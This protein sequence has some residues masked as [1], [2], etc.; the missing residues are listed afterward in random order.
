MSTSTGES[1]WCRYCG[2]PLDGHTAAKHSKCRKCRKRILIC[3]VIVHSSGAGR[4]ICHVPCQC[5]PEYY[6]TEEA[7]PLAQ[8][9]YAITHPDYVAPDD[10]DDYTDNTQL[11]TTASGAT[12]EA[13]PTYVD[14]FWQGDDFGFYDINQHLIL[15]RKSDWQPATTLYEGEPTPCVQLY[16]GTTNLWYFT[17]TLDIGD[18]QAVAKTRKGKASSARRTQTTNA[19]S[20]EAGQSDPHRRT[21]SKESIDPLQWDQARFE[22]ETMTAGIANLRVGESSQAPATSDQRVETVTVSARYSGKGKVTFKPKDGDLSGQRMV[23]QKKEWVKDGSGYK[24]TSETYNC[25]FVA[26]EIKPAK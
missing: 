15:S 4:K 5:G 7:Q 12:S 8:A 19:I 14:L 23:S 9:D 1:G 21:D 18:S 11:S 6:P 2:H 16:D 25:I 22:E 17:W 10:E 3:Q 13:G 24:L 20:S 26:K